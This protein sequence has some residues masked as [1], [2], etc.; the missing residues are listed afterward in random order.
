MRSPVATASPIAASYGIAMEVGQHFLPHR[1]P[2]LLPD[3]AVN[4]LGA[5]GVVVWYLVRP[6]LDCKPVTEFVE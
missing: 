1:T 5:S 4:T 6:H 2:F 3:A